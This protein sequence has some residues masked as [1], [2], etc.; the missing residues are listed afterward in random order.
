MIDLHPI[1]EG[2]SADVCRTV[3][4]GSPTP[5]QQAAYDLYLKAQQAAVAKAKAGV[6]MNELEGTLHGILRDAGHADH[7][8]GPPLHGVGI[9]FEEPP[10]PA[11]H[12]FF[13]GEK[14]PPPLEKNVVVAV[15]N[16]GLYTGRFGVR[17]EDTVVVG[18]ERPEVLTNAGRSL[19]GEGR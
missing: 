3:C 5:E 1:V 8:F 2:Y 17:V 9:D 16:C 7:I 19:L 6:T 14:A 10:L 18:A 15:G 13:H 11:G 4:V 12:A